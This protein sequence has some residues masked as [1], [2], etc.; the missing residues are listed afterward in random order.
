MCMTRIANKMPFDTPMTNLKINTLIVIAQNTNFGLF[1]PKDG[2]P[3]T[4]A[5]TIYT[6]SMIITQALF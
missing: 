4:I 6:K 1:P 3:T 2:Q 5:S